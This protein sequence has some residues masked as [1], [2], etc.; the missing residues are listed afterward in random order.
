MWYPPCPEELASPVGAFEGITV[1]A[2]GSAGVSF[3]VFRTGERRTAGVGLE[4]PSTHER[5]RLMNWDTEGFLISGE[6]ATKEV[7]FREAEMQSLPRKGSR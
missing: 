1:P 6:I 5:C 4:S 3:P 2:L 7:M